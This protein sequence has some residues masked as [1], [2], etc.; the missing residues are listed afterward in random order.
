MGNPLPEAGNYQGAEGWDWEEGR[1]QFPLLPLVIHHLLFVW[2]LEGARLRF[3]LIFPSLF[4]LFPPP[5]SR[6][7]DQ[8]RVSVIKHVETIG[9]CP[10][11]KKSGA[12]CGVGTS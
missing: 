6:S 2:L 9:F 7:V 10:G 4:S 3:L 5:R 12:K 8:G 11:E 1:A